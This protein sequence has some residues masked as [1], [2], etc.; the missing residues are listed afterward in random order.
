MLQPADNL[1]PILESVPPPV[2]RVISWHLGVLREIA[3][4]ITNACAMERLA[5][6]PGRY[7]YDLRYGPGH[8]QVR[9]DASVEHLTAYQALAEAHGLGWDTICVAL[10]GYVAP[11]D[12]GPAVAG[13]FPQAPDEG[14]E[15]S[16]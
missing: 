15:G 8:A 10:G 13:W 9:L 3:G 5:G 2:Q 1:H 14:E 16:I 4:A 11:P 7:E 6:A 12:V